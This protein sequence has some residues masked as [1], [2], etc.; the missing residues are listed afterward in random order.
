LCCA[1]KL[2][3]R[4]KPGHPRADYFRRIDALNFSMRHDDGQLPQDLNAASAFSSFAPRTTGLL[5]R[6][7]IVRPSQLPPGV[8]AEFVLKLNSLQ[9]IREEGAS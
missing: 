9:R 5:R 1:A 8:C 4:R 2:Y 3:P 7:S 6:L